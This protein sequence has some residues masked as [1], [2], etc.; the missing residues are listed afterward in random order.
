[1]HK[2]LWKLPIEVYN[3][4]DPIHRAL[5]K[6]G[7]IAADQAAEVLAE[8]KRVRAAAGKEMTVGVARKTIRAWLDDSE[9][10]RA[11][12]THVEALLSG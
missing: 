5:A 12:E 7:S 3:S 6:A 2:H 10:G 8:E 1:M 11:I 9:V 4:D